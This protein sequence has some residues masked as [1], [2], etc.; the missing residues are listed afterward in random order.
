MFDL[1]DIRAYVE[2]AEAG[3]FSRAAARLGLSK[4]MVSRRIVRLENELGAQLLSRTT[5][6]VAVTEAGTTFKA[7]AERALAELETARDAVGGEE[8]SLAGTLRVTA[9][10]SFGTA[11]LGSVFAELASRHPRLHVYTSYSDRRVDLVAERFDVAIRIGSLPDSSL[12]AR[13]IAPLHG[14]VIAS[15][16]YIEKRGAP[17]SLAALTQH[18]LLIGDNPNWR[19]MAGKREVVVPVHGRFGSDSGEALIAACIAGL[20]IAMLPTFIAGAHLASGAVLPLL[21]QFP[22]PEFGMYVVRPP[23][24]S[25]MTG[26]VRA[27]TELLVEKFGGEPYWD[28]CYQHRKAQAAVASSE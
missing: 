11:H 9:P 16:A 22:V 26:K 6:G 13:R 10:L 4:S 8:Q 24:A 14:A 2:V 1:E 19:F 17:T 20:G 25:H 3:G 23:P 28:A 18:D 27:L 5:R 21:A 15:P 7:Y 12:V